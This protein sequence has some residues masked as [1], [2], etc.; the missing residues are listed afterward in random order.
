M[1]LRPTSF[2]ARLSAIFIGMVWAA[3]GGVWSWRVLFHNS[4]FPTHDTRHVCLLVLF[5]GVMLV[6]SALRPSKPADFESETP[7]L[8]ADMNDDDGLDVESLV[9]GD[10]VD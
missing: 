8:H 10:D 7:D 2:L 5:A 3:A 4:D 6:I 1:F 9:F